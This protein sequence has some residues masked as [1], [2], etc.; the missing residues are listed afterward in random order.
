MDSHFPISAFDAIY[1]IDLCEP[2]LQI[3]RDRIAKRGW[4]NVTVLCQDAAEFWLPEWSEGRDPRGSV[5]FVTMSYS[6]T[7]VCPIRV[8]EC[9]LKSSQIPRFYTVFD[10][11]DYVLSR[12][13]GLIGVADFYTS[14]KQVSLI[15]KSIGGIGKECGWFTRW[16]WQI[17]FE[18]DHVSQSVNH[19]ATRL[20]FQLYLGSAQRTYLEHRFGTVSHLCL[21]MCSLTAT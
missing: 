17:F 15:D 13:H 4:T 9:V 19:V 5:G 8:Q 1:L 16:F 11:V 6:I 21:A 3:A 7:M 20:N 14:A 2:L 18:F 12:E 10:R